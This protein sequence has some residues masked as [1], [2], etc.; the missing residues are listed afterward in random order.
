MKQTNFAGNGGG[1]SNPNG[2]DSDGPGCGGGGAAGWIRINA[3]GANPVLA[4]QADISPNAASG[5]FT[6]GALAPPSP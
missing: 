5:A 4:A 1:G 6:I 2:V 3:G